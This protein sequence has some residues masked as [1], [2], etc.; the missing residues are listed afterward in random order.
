VPHINTHAEIFKPWV[1]EL[2]D[3]LLRITVCVID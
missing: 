2:E 1:I 3:L